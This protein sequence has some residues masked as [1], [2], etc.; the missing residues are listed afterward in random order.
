MG[1]A[2]ERRGLVIGKVNRHV[3]DV[4]ETIPEDKRNYSFS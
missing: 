2:R 4:I 3:D 1:T